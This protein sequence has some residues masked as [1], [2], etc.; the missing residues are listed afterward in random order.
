M[1]ARLESVDTPKITEHVEQWL[2]HDGFHVYRAA[3]AAEVSPDAL[4]RY[5]ART[6]RSAS[7]GTAA[8]E[9]AQELAPRDYDR[10]DWSDLAATVLSVD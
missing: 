1:T 5:V 7:E 10:I 4:S 3:N 6:L 9:C 2:I 8:W